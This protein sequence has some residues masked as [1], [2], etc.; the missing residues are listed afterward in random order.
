MVSTLHHK[1]DPAG[2]ILKWK[3]CLCA[4]GDHQVYGD[5][6]WTTFA[7]VV[8]STTIHC[9]I[10]LALL[11]GWH[12]HSINFIMAYTQ[13]K[14]KTDIFMKLPMGTTLPNVDP[15]KHLLKL[16]QNAMV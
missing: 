16:Q 6:Y 4:G 11:L 9:V 7:P 5:M 8:S 14:V 10:I 12:M 2:D 13:A 1:W 15:N 3:A